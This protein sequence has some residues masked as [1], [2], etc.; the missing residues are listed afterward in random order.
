MKKINEFFG[1]PS[2]ASRQAMANMT[3]SRRDDIESLYYIL[4]YLAGITSPFEGKD[5]K[6]LA[7]EKSKFCEN[8]PHIVSYFSIDFIHAM[9]IFTEK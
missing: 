9:K 3:Q 7:G 6:K 1:E 2:F 4:A 5:L 8:L